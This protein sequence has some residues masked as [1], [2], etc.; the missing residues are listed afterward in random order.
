MGRVR[1]APR[2]WRSRVA[3]PVAFGLAMGLVLAAAMGLPGQGTPRWMIAMGRMAPVGLAAMGAV[4]AAVVFRSS[5]RAALIAAVGGLAASAWMI[6][7][8]AYL[9]GAEPGPSAWLGVPG[10]GSVPMA[11]AAG[12]LGVAAAGLA[13]VVGA[14]G[15]SGS[16]WRWRSDTWPS[17]R[18]A[19]RTSSGW[20][21]DSCWPR[22]SGNGRPSC[23]PRARPARGGP[24]RR[25]LRGWAARAV[26][27]AAAVLL[28]AATVSGRLFRATGERRAFGMSASPTAYAH[29]AARFAGRPGLPEH[30]LVF[31]L[32]Q[33]GVYVFHNGPARKVFMDGRLEVPTRETF[34]TYTLLERLLGE[35]GRGW[36]KALR[37]IGDPL[38]L[39]DH[40]AHAG[41]E[42]T[43][44]ADPE[45]RCVYY[46]PVASIFLSRRRRDLEA[47]FPAVDFL[48]RHFRDPA[49]RAVPP[50]STSLAEGRGLLGLAS[51][52][53]GRPGVTW[54]LRA[55]L[56]LPACDRFRQA[57]DP[58]GPPRAI[59]PC[60]A[61]PSRA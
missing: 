39:L 37:R 46:D 10:R 15:R 19:T 33:A 36:R 52:L 61:R 14:R 21:P 35:G 60:W 42:A 16:P 58:D 28:I 59:G 9:F 53:R 17:R 56:L 54:G 29:D 13:V 50:S 31:S 30:A 47:A 49:W 44:L 7:L 32:R 5:R 45:W 48:A 18:S 43:L 2:R 27:A 25:P 11:W 12:V 22:T 41:A 3:G 38:V 55:S 8:R 23:R 51:A 1:R 20:R 24:G 4:A 40:E 57:T 26:V 6:W 34:E